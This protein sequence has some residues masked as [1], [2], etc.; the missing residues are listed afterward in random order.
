MY[1]CIHI[2]LQTG[3]KEI[4]L[5]FYTKAFRIYSSECDFSIAKHKKNYSVY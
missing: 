3:N 5:V 4:R 1:V 2:E